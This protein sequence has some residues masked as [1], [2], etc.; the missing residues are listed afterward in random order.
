[1]DVKIYTLPNCGICHMV[2]MKLQQKNIPYTEYSL[3]DYADTFKIYSAPV[4]QI[5]ETDI[6]TSSIEINNW[7][8]NQ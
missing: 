2:K 7:I 3:E 4:L 1:M 8:N 6:L 5:N